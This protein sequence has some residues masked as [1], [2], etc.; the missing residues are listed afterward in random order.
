MKTPEWTKNI[1]GQ[2]VFDGSEFLCALLVSNL[3][4]KVSHWE[5]YK[6]RVS[7]CDEGMFD[8]YEIVEDDSGQDLF[9]GWDWND[10]EYLIP[11]NK[12]AEETLHA[13]NCEAQND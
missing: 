10:F 1:Q 6:L 2:S 4:T 5:F 12:D 3:D 13:W 7:C 11:L 9:S 8:L